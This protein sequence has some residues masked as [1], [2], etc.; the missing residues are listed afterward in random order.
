MLCEGLDKLAGL[1][2]PDLDGVVVAPGG[3]ER[4]RNGADAPDVVV[5]PE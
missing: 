2:V 5:V 3:D 4:V 1:D